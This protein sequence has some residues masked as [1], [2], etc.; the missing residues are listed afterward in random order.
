MRLLVVLRPQPG[1][2]ATAEAAREMGLE[3]LVLPLF[4]V[5]PVDWDVPDPSEF[6][7]LLLTSANAVRHGGPDL[8]M[9]RSLP[10]HCVGEATAKAARDYGFEVTTVGQGRVDPL[11]R[12]LPA[13]LRLL[14]LCGVHRREPE[15]PAQ[16]I[17]VV[18]VYRSDALPAPSRLAEIEGAVAA[19]HSPRAGA[20]LS[21]LVDES[22]LARE[23][24]AVAAI[25]REAADA[26]GGGWETVEIAANPS[27]VAL[28]ALA[29]R[30]C[31][32][33]G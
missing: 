18:P 25:S 10:A 19:I 1:A 27:E 32:N 12:S 15:A 22:A 21:S 6:D 33:P 11:L 29:A 24:I 2:T 28:L 23:R 14:H 9:L 8:E 16:G 31:N 30:L 13:G 5:D 4:A 17:T 7:G 3:T 20:R 26:A